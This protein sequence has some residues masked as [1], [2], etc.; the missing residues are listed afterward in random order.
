MTLGRGT[1]PGPAGERGVVS[2]EFA[3]TVPSAVLLFAVLVQGLALLNSHVQTQAA[4][5][6][7]VRIAAIAYDET[8]AAASA[9][10]FVA[11]VDPAARLTLTADGPY[12][13]A[14]VERRVRSPLWPRGITI[15]SA[16]TAIREL[17]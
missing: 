9:R 17:S 3:F 16:A 12:V 4:A 1:R 15:A 8:T 7:A 13:I 11:R 10:E 14:S 6:E 5:R 2:L